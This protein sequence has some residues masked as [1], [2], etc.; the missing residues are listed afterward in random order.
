MFD[1]R[2]ILS[3]VSGMNYVAENERYDGRM[4]Y[5][6][7]GRSGLKLPEIS[8]GFWHNFGDVDDLTVSRAI[9]RKAFDEGITHFD[10]A[11]NYG[12]PPG[13]AERNCGEILKKDFAGYRDELIL[14]S[15]AGY[16]MWDGP[17]GDWGSR[18]YILSSL[19]QSLKRLQVDYVDI[20]YHHRPDPETPLEES[21]GA[22][23]T[24]VQQGKALYVGVSNYPAEEAR[25]ALDILKGM[26]VPCLIHQ[27]RYSLLGRW[28]EDGLTDVL[29]EQGVGCITFSPLAQGQL[30]QR[31]LDGIP[32]DSRAAKPHGFLQEDQVLRHLEKVRSLNAIAQE[33][34]DTLAAMALAWTLQNPT[35]TSTLVGVSSVAQLE[36]NL[37]A[38]KVSAFS[39]AEITQINKITRAGTHS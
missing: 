37:A 14:A 9:M 11:N 8:L 10:F 21:M 35:V 12:P 27:A 23:A 32:S 4:E 16:L 39:D 31:Y 22:L 1:L 33:R 29:D 15:K 3:S 6:R 2:H 13:A 28:I 34:G 36:Q 5:R 25:K 26:G 24:A 17:Y 38:L 7:C 20:F 30:T 19:D 18:K